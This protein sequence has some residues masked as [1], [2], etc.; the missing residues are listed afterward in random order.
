MR[1]GL[2]CS[3]SSHKIQTCPFRGKSTLRRIYMLSRDYKSTNTLTK[4]NFHKTIY[5]NTL[6]IIV[7]MM[8]MMLFL[9]INR[10]NYLQGSIESI[11]LCIEIY[12]NRT[13]L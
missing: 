8:I 1:A 2:R 5:F 4:A 11:I 6:G 13:T 3:K 9:I 10:L 12:L 7:I